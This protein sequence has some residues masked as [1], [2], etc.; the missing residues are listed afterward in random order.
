MPYAPDMVP[1]ISGGRTIVRKLFE[2]S[3]MSWARTA[4]SLREA[5]RESR[6][7]RSQSDATGYKI[8]EPESFIT[9]LTQKRGA[10]TLF[11]LGSGTSVNGLTHEN[12]AHIATHR[13]VGINNW[14]VH[15][16]IPDVYA[17]ESVP[18]VGD[19]KDLQRAIKLLHRDDIQLAHPSVL[20]LRPATAGAGNDLQL[21]PRPLRSRTFLYGRI[22]PSTR[23]HHNLTRDAGALLK[24][25]SARHPAVF[26]DSGASILRMVGLGLALGL[27]RIVFV[28]VDLNTT[29][30]FWED[31]TKYAFDAERPA[32]RNNQQAPV[33]GASA[34]QLHETMSIGTRPFSVTQMLSALA[35]ALARSGRMQMFVSSA[36]SELAEFLPV[37]EWP[38]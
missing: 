37:Y 33:G 8:F 14:G 34:R 22:S 16:F 38:R 3:S 23:R 1:K 24:K 35:P 7:L 18:Q 15:A 30:Y 10:T 28:G 36:S 19:G 13:S 31:N 21:L 25:L 9:G 29:S 20:A 11:I 6:F 17:L 26:L 27:S 12:F 4:L 2:V 5:E 32:P